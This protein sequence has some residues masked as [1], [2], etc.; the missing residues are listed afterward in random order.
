MKKLLI[1]VIAAFT[2]VGCIEDSFDTSP[3]AQP[4]FDV[5]ELDMGVQF[6]DNP[7]PTSKLM[8]Y[9]PNSK[10]INLQT[11]K[12]RSGEYFRLNVDGQS[13]KEFHDVEIRPNDSIYV[14]VE[15]TLPPTPTPEPVIIS[16]EL[17]VTTN[18]VLK[19]LTIK[20]LAQ[21][22]ERHNRRVID[23]D[24]RFTA[25]V[26]HV[27]FDTLRVARGATLTLSAGV[28]LLFHDK[29]ALIVDGSLV[30]E[31]TA[32]NPVIMRGDRTGNVVAD[33]SYDVMSNQWEGVRFSRESRNNLLSHTEIMN[34]CQGVTLDSLAQLEMVNSRLYNSGMTQLAVSGDSEVTALG[35]EIS[36]AASA[37]LLLEGG[38]YL[39]NRCT[40]A[41]WYLFTWPDM[42]IVEF[43]TP[44]KT[45]AE[46]SNSIIYGRDASVGDYGDVEAVDIWFRRCL[47][48]ENGV[49]DGRY[50][51]CLWGE[52][53]KLDY[54]LT[55]Y[56][57]DYSPTAGSPA[58]E[59]AL[60]EFDAAELPTLDRRGRSRSLTLG[61]YAPAPSEEIPAE[62]N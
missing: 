26:P 10:L 34:T 51:Q 36:N 13:G 41:N 1:L 12:M 4:R 14:F 37:L 42:A 46:F 49:D 11:V 21:N 58:I 60:P 25:D 48:K 23:A 56:T 52:D 55:E 8:I 61:A 18:G 19:T 54:S 22:V 39:F 33:I 38:T 62:N 50:L 9:N 45:S 15:C 2:L 3:S 16:D 28:S 27:V 47:F 53:P 6:T 43:I 44:E 29:A 59:A 30:S 57:F 5:E 17:E 32:E 20:A 7:S 24:T 40:I 35:C 31:G